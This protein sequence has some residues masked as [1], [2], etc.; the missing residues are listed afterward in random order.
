MVEN[1]GV[2]GKA[3]RH[4]TFLIPYMG[5]ISHVIAAS[6][7]HFG[8][9]SRALPTAGEDA[10][11][12][13]DKHVYTETCFPLKGV[14]GDTLSFLAEES[15]RHGKAVVE[16]QYLVAL[17]TTCGPCRFGKYGEVLRQ[18]MDKEGF[19]KVPVAGPTTETNYTDLLGQGYS[20][21]DKLRFYHLVMK[22]VLAGDLLDDILLRYRPYAA[23]RPAAN[24]LKEECLDELVAILEAGGDMK[25]LRQWAAVTLAAFRQYDGEKRHPLVLYSGEIYMRKHDP[26]TGQ[27]IERLEEKGLEMI[28]PPVMEWIEYINITNV[29]VMQR[30]WKWAIRGGEVKRA[31]LSLL[32]LVLYR[33]NYRKIRKTREELTEPVAAH[34]SDRHVLPDADELIRM[35][36]EAGEFH[37]QI[38]GEAALSIGLGYFLMNDRVRSRNGAHLAGMFHVGPFTCMQEGVATAKIDSLAAALRRRNPEAMFPVLHGFFGDSPNPNLEAE[39]AVFTEQCYQ[40]RDLLLQGG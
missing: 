2:Y 37:G 4:R 3:L 10:F 33:S 36:E 40:K 22:A 35:L 21:R 24:R 25:R 20:L 11:R 16:N 12:M 32:R 38:T 7:R 27:V 29:G 26:Y 13:A 5:D 19:E 15:R 39:I 18:F 9:D 17:P 30:A 23:D 31:A 8:I 1:N 28:R 34:L 14:V 6:L